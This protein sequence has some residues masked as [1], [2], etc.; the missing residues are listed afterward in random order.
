MEDA[1]KNSK[2]EAQACTRIKTENW[3]PSQGRQNK[4]YGRMAYDIEH[5]I[6]Y[7]IVYDTVHDIVKY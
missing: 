7:D 2:D 6:V 1:E 4:V 5:D 3:R